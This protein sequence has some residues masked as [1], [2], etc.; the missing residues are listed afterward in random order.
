MCVDI[1]MSKEVKVMLNLY[2]ELVAK[3][4]CCFFFEF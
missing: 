1:N 4:Y 3:H 2:S